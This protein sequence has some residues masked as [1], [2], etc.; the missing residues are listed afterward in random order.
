MLVLDFINV[1]N[2]DSILVREMDGGAQKFGMLVDCGHDNLVRE[3]HQREPDPRSKRLYAGEFLRRHGVSRLDMLLIT[4]FH[5][6]HI[7][8]LGR[9]LE[10]VEAERLVSSYI[11]PADSVP[12][13]P[14]GDNSA[15]ASGT[16]AGAGG[17]ALPGGGAFSAYG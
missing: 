1:G 13:E 16:G 15:G 10:A 12:L 17:A 14:D 4:H 11:P 6:D 2:G 5:R 9:V 3:D 7:G 8:G